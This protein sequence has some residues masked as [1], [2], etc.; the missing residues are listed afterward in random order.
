MVVGF[1]DREHLLGEVF[2]AGEDAVFEQ[3]SVEDREDD[4]DLVEPG[5]VGGGELEAPAGV[6]G[7]PVLDFL[8]AAG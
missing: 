6:R 3:S 1:D 2:F 4:L 5:G 8:G 7:E